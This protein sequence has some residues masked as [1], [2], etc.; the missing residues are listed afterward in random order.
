[1]KKALLLLLA[2]MLVG[3]SGEGT[4]KKKEASV[5]KE[6]ENV[7]KEEVV[8]EEKVVPVKYA[9]VDPESKA[10]VEKFVKKYNVQADLIQQS[11]E[12]PIK[13]DKI[14]EPITSELNEEKSMFSQIL[15]ETDFKQ[16][17]GHYKIVAKYNKSKKIT[18]YNISVEASPANEVN[19]EA[20]EWQEGFLAAMTTTDAIGLSIDTFEVHLNKA[21]EEEKDTHSYIDSNYKVTILMPDI[22]L[23]VFEISYD[24][25][26]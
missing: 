7:K 12:V 14:P 10:A 15:L 3:C 26:K 8:K 22:D 9:E 21:L 17:K 19:E 24:L 20:D 13:I 25:T 11:K 4:E 16:Y 23:G 18:G 6:E 5:N 2:V 1:M